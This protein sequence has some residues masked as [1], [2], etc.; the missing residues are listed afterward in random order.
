MLIYRHQNAVRN[1]DIKIANRSFENVLQVK[2][3]ET[4]VTNQNLIQKEIKRKSNSGNACYHLVQN[5]LS[6]RL[7]K[8]VTIKYARL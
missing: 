7:S 4:I 3:L 6:S 5:L 8:N 2:Y 1:L